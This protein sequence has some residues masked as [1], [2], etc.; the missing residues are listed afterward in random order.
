MKK[1][2]LSLGRGIK[3]R[4]KKLRASHSCKHLLIKAVDTFFIQGF[5]RRQQT[6]TLI[7]SETT[8]LS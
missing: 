5:I 2:H 4:N 6:L 8:N 3:I 1:N 7:I